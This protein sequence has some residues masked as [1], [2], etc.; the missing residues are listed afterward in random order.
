MRW[1]ALG[2]VAIS[3]GAAALWLGR[4]LPASPT[5]APR[6]V[7]E[8]AGVANP[9][10]PWAVVPAAPEGPYQPPLLRAPATIEPRLPRIYG[11][12]PEMVAKLQAKAQPDPAREALGERRHR[13][14]KEWKAAGLRRGQRQHGA[15]SSSY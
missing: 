1:L 7:E 10:R 11:L 13:E 5:E 4:P 2:I 14:A 3:A 9:P 6:T 15:Q 8:P 12:E